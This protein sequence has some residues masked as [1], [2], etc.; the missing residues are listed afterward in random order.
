MIGGEDVR[1]TATQE[2]AKGKIMMAFKGRLQCVS[3]GDSRA[4]GEKPLNDL[5]HLKI[6]V[7]AC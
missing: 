3:I 6:C 7:A 5:F 4:Q 2:G 1:I